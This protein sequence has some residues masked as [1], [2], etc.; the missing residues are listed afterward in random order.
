M[1]SLILKDN[2]S[3]IV[4]NEFTESYPIN[5]KYWNKY[6]YQRSWMISLSKILHNS[7][8]STALITDMNYNRSKGTL[9]AWIVYRRSHKVVISQSI[10]SERNR[11]IRFDEYGGLIIGNSLIGSFS[12][13]K[14]N[15]NDIIEF[16]HGNSFIP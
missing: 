5:Y 4:V 12:K 6:D 8:S 1:F 3:T 13:W 9:A 16:C 11:E 15:I 14:C 7:N 10:F 2:Y